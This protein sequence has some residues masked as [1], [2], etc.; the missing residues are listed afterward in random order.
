MPAVLLDPYPQEPHPPLPR[1]HLPHHHRVAGVEAV[2]KLA[3]DI[4]GG[5]GQG[6]C[7]GG[8]KNKNV[9]YTNIL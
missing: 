5:G 3:G 4:C 7:R 6:E 8:V 2:D 9:A 1:R